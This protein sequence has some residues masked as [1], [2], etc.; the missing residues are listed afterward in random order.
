[1]IPRRINSAGSGTRQGNNATMTT[2]ATIGG[3]TARCTIGGCRSHRR[4]AFFTPTAS[5]A[6]QNPPCTR[7]L[8]FNRGR[9]T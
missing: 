9:A 3:M 7:P 4:R 2:R 6:R 5:T 8:M 1:M